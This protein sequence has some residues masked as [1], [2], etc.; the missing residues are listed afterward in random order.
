MLTDFGMVIFM[1][2]S[3]NIHVHDISQTKERNRQMKKSYYNF[4]FPREGGKTILYNSRTGAMA[5]LDTEHTEQFKNLTEA[6]LAEKN[7][8][9][10]DALYKNG[11]AVADEVSELDMIRYDMLQARFGNQSLALTL[12]ITKDCNFGCKYC[13]EKN[14]L[15][16]S[17]LTDEIKNAIVKYV[18]EH[19]IMGGSLHITWYGGEPLLDMESITSLTNAFLEIC[20]NKS[21][22]YSA[23]I[24][25]NGYL[26]SGEIAKSLVKCKID[27]VQITLDGDEDTHNSRRPLKN[28]EPSYR[29]IW[30]NI[31]GLMEF[32][33]VLKVVLRVNVDKTN[34]NA[35]Y[36]VRNKILKYNMQD[37][38]FVYPGRVFSIESCHNDE[39]CYSS[40]EFAILEQ[41]Y[42]GDSLENG[43]EQ[44][45]KPRYMVCSADNAHAMV[46]DSGGDMYK[47]YMHI[48]NKS[49][50]IGNIVCDKFYHEEELYMFLL[51]DVTKEQKCSKCKYLPLCMGGC[52]NEHLHHGECCTTYQYTLDKYI[53]HYFKSK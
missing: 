36:D 37:F 1:L 35:L 9:F 25:T 42:N 12:A 26:L 6:E 43:I 51:S 10:A 46:I 2:I 22:Q 7:P 50:C 32:R 45:P 34:V 47:C 40:K 30:K 41:E 17:Y 5:Q 23:S 20:E 53:K 15:D 48:G 52:P 44:I 16:K 27:Q 11:F 18:D 21:I 24:I 29:V 39:I 3:N 49:H 28:G 33:K 8:K 19:V 14:V 31:L 13:Y 4:L 38:I